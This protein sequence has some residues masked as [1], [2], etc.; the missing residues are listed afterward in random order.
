M[1]EVTKEIKRILKEK[2]RGIK[3]ATEAM[4]GI[5]KNLHSQ[6]TDDIGRAALGS[7]DSY[8]LKNLLDSLEIRIADYEGTA[9]RE[10]SGQLDNMWNKGGEMVSSALRTGGLGAGQ[11]GL[12]G[13]INISTSSLTA[14]K[15]YSNTYLEKLFGDT[16]FQIK[17]EINLGILG[18]KT[19]QEVS[20]SIGTTIDKGKFANIAL[21]AETI[22]QTEMGR[23]F[24]EAAQL[25]MGEAAQ[26]VKGLEKQWIH[27]GHPRT[28]RPS[29]IAAAGQHVP[30]DQPFMVGGIPMMFPRAPNAPISEVIHCGCDHVPYHANWGQ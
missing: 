8:S 30:V 26:H 18:A 4:L 24:S 2:D 23:I 27:A 15:D 9:V 25:R 10:L 16:W 11:I 22:T 1:S 14:L 20:T 13:H 28:P 5:M 29:H 12:M 17:G 21:R 7:W 19:P 6:I 3:T